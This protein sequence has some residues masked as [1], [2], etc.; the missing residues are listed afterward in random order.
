MFTHQRQ[1]EDDLVWTELYTSLN[2][3]VKKS[4]N[5]AGIKSWRGQ[6]RELAE[7][8]LQEAVIR[9]FLQTQKAVRGE[10]API[11]SLFHF[12]KKVA[13]NHIYDVARKDFRL[14]RPAND[15]T[16]QE[17]MVADNWTDSTEEI[18]NDIENAFLFALIAQIIVDFPVK[19][20]NALL[21]DLAKL[22]PVDDLCSPLQQALKKVGIRLDTYRNL[23]PKTSLERG[24]HAAL[25]S[26]AY[27]RVKKAVHTRLQ[28]QN[29][30]YSA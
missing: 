30:S 25:L 19:Q 29:E 15:I 22:S 27:K 9:T 2:P 6:E 24:R 1:N 21:I 8:V 5:G 4:V 7:D 18:L 13:T 17:K 16:V 28:L 26:I 3:H 20:R 14:I 11:V 12:S 10:A 23:A